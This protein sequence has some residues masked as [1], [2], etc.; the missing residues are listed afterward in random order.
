MSRRQNHQTPRLPIFRDL[1]FRLPWPNQRKCFERVLNHCNLWIHSYHR[2]IRIVNGILILME[3]CAGAKREQM[4]DRFSETP[5]RWTNIPAHL[6]YIKRNITSYQNI[7]TGRRYRDK[8]LIT[9]AK[10]S[11]IVSV[12]LMWLMNHAWNLSSFAGFCVWFRET[13]PLSRAVGKN[14]FQKRYRIITACQFINITFTPIRPSLSPG[15]ANALTRCPLQ[16]FIYH[17]CPKIPDTSNKCLF[18]RKLSEHSFS[19]PV[20]FIRS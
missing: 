7:L 14:I 15:S 4:D 17:Y 1:S 16:G 18:T 20:R 3:M 6:W 13:R 2:C 10:L 9:I 5:I 19:F 8:I 11:L 12:F